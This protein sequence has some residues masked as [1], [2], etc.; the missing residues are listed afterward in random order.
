MSAPASKRLNKGH[1]EKMSKDE[2]IIALQAHLLSAAM[3]WM[4]E[5]GQDPKPLSASE[6]ELGDTAITLVDEIKRIINAS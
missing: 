1:L 5:R 4:V 3:Q 6:K 2:H